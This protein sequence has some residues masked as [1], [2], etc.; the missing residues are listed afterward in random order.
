MTALSKL[1]EWEHPKPIWIVVLLLGLWI[2]WPV[3]LVVFAVRDRTARRVET[4][5]RE[6][7]AGG[8]WLH[9]ST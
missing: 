6:P 3:G 2:I 7:L 8:N 5:R 1:N 4:R 9:A